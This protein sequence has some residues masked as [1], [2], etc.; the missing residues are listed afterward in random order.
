[1]VFSINTCVCLGIALSHQTIYNFVRSNARSRRRDLRW[2]FQDARPYLHRTCENLSN[3]CR[4]ESLYRRNVRSSNCLGLHIFATCNANWY[5]LAISSLLQHGRVLAS[6]VG[7]PVI[8]T[9][10]NKLFRNGLPKSIAVP[11]PI[12]YRSRVDTTATVLIG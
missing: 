9:L 11:V 4:P 2:C 12:V 5:K 1:M 10:R 3:A 8:T 6:S 7:N